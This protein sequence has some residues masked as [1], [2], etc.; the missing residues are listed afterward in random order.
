MLD[1]ECIPTGGRAENTTLGRKYQL[2]RK[3]LKGA[4][5]DYISSCQKQIL[6][7]NE[8]YLIKLNFQI[9]IKL[10]DNNMQLIWINLLV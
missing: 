2:C 8:F 6:T 7:G 4:G 3:I 5:Q 10:R 9:E 1:K